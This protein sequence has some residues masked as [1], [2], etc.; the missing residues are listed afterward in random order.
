MRKPESLPGTIILVDNQNGERLI[1]YLLTYVAD[2]SFNGTICR[3]Y[4]NVD[5]TYFVYIP[6]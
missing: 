2:C 5:E 1:Q 4:R 6:Y 3:E